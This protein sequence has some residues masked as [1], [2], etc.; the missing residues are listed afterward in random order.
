MRH[1][2]DMFMALKWGHLDNRLGQFTAKK[3]VIVSR[4]QDTFS[5]HQC[6]KTRYSCWDIRTISTWKKPG[7]L[8][9]SCFL[10][11]L[12][13]T[14]RTEQVPNRYHQQDV[15]IFSSCI[16]WNKTRY[17]WWDIGKFLTPKTTKLFLTKTFSSCV[18]GDRT[19]WADTWC[20]PDPHQEVRHN[21]KLKI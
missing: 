10:A 6:D 11:M 3:Q 21:T 2:L 18:S 17:S 13:A 15:E 14:N 9:T 4:N 8:T 7:S 1:F 20:S 12:L 5:L 19:R 16:S